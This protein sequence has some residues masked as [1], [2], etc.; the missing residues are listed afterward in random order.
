MLL[1][2]N[3][4]ASDRDFTS[5]VNIFLLYSSNKALANLFN[6]GESPYAIELLT[7]ELEA[8]NKKDVRQSPAIEDAI[9]SPMP[10]GTDAI[11]NSLE[12]EWRP[13]YQQMNLLR[14]KLDQYNG[15][16][17]TTV[18]E[19]CHQICVEILTLEK[20]C[21]QIWAKRDYYNANGRLPDVK[22]EI[23]PIPIDPLQLAR[24]IAS[25]QRQIRRYRGTKDTNSIHA[26]L[27][28]DYRDKYKKATGNDYKE[29]D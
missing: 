16:N 26:Q 8:M 23:A 11:L 22:N 4:L 5:G 9:L 15:D 21:Q 2:D 28:K 7:E 1:I 13:K 19:V 25:C 27:Y 20:E 18:R 14:H 10:K 3:W 24:F 6:Q 12:A 29:K 17:S